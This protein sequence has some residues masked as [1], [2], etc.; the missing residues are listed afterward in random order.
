MT[1][2][3]RFIGDDPAVVDPGPSALTVLR[4]IVTL[5]FGILQALIVLRI[6]LLL[7]AANQDNSIVA[8]ILGVSDPFVEPFRGVFRLDEVRGKTGSLLD[9]GA[10]VALVGWTLIEALVLGI[11]GILERRRPVLL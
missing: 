7:L 8:F 3:R 10:V 2:E 1:Y 6:V 5:L 11:V 9:I 4:R